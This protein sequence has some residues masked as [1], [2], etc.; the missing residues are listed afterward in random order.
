[1]TDNL[2]N[3]LIT[4]NDKINHTGFNYEGLIFRRSISSYQYE[5]STKADILDKL[6]TLMF[7]MVESIKMIK[8]TVNYSLRKDY[9][10]FN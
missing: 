3:V 4:R 7:H 2:R 6:D 10:K 5:E 9:T 1:M 8:K